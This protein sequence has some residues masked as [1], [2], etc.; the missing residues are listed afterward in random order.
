[1]KREIKPFKDVEK[2]DLAYNCNT[3]EFE[4]VVLAKGTFEELYKKYDSAWGPEDIK[5]DDLMQVEDMKEC[6]AI[7]QNPED[8]IECYTNLI[9]MYNYDPSSV[10]CY[11]I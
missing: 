11:K 2:S 10:E 3:E 8:T 9:F 5:D 6:V 4:G 1:M 7:T